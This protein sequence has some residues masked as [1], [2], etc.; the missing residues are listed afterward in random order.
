MVRGL[1]R[2]LVPST[3]GVT[4]GTPGDTGVSC[5]TSEPPESIPHCVGPRQ[6][7][8]SRQLLSNPALGSVAN[9]PSTALEILRLAQIGKPELISNITRVSPIV[10]TRKQRYI[11]LTFKALP[12]A[13]TLPCLSQFTLVR[14]GVREVNKKDEAA[15][16][17]RREEKSSE[18]KPL[19]RA[20]Q[21][22]FYLTCTLLASINHPGTS[23]V[24]KEERPGR[25]HT[26]KEDKQEEEDPE[27]FYA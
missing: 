24:T 20:C 1:K 13:R 2:H 12:T 18:E 22:S 21:S 7:R 25:S 14:D 4:R 3:G 10:R 26:S 6:T 19:R 16:H 17:F 23:S 5:G 9:N 27:T 15:P 8:E 11:D